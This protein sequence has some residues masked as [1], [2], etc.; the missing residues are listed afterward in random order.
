MSTRV[1]TRVA[2]ELQV[3]L[4]LLHHYLP[5]SPLYVNSVLF[6]QDEVRLPLYYLSLFRIS[7]FIN[8]KTNKNRFFVCFPHFKKKRMQ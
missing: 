5:D 6:N 7:Q 4:Y 3:E 2:A 1:A 8:F